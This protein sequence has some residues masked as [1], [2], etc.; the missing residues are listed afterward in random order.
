MKCEIAPLSRP[1]LSKQ[2]DTKPLSRS[3]PLKPT[4]THLQTRLVAKSWTRSASSRSLACCL[5]SGAADQSRLLVCARVPRLGSRPRSGS[6]RESVSIDNGARLV[7][8]LNLSEHPIE[9]KAVCTLAEIHG[10]QLVPFRQPSG[11]DWPMG[12]P[13]HWRDVTQVL[14]RLAFSHSLA[15]RNK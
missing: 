13:L 12:E 10:G 4:H 8:S 9:T 14:S 15:Y 5:S 2:F 1:L 11:S 3:E 7:N 6:E